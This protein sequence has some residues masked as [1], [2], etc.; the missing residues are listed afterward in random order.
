MHIAIALSRTLLNAEQFHYQGE[1]KLFLFFSFFYQLT[2]KSMKKHEHYK[3]YLYYILLNKSEENTNTN[4]IS[5]QAATLPT[6]NN[7]NVNVIQI[8]YDKQTKILSQYYI[9]NF[10][11][12]KQT[13]IS[14]LHDCIV[15][16]IVYP[17]IL[18]LFERFVVS[19]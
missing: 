12:K 2:E 16:L 14:M 4:A 15:G 19:F 18:F 17:C 10:H 3:N 6:K 8:C 7:R 1:K 13:L 11:F 9:I 5:G